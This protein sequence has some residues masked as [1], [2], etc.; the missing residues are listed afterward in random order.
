MSTT[1]DRVNL[2]RTRIADAN[3]GL[4]AAEQEME[5]AIAQLAPV[6]VGDKRMTSEALDRAF[7]KLKD[8]R[9]LIADLE[10]MLAAALLTPR[11]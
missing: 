11:A 6:L 3:S 8:A 2:L 1:D 10:K 9:H 7:L 4:A 5:Q